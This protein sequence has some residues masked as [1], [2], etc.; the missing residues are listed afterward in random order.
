[1]QFLL[2][3]IPSTEN[4]V[5]RTEHRA[6]STEHRVP[7]TENRA[8]RTEYLLTSFPCIGKPNT[9][10]LNDHHQVH[11]LWQQRLKSLQ[12]EPPS[13]WPKKLPRAMGWNWGK[14][15]S[16][17]LPIVNSN[18]ALKRISAVWISSS[19]SLPSPPPIT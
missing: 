5:P 8:P 11:D 14:S 12:A 17:N 10:I 3:R 2:F 6:P 1:M 16:L 7:S 15:K 13:T 4:R 18:L 19:S 9:V